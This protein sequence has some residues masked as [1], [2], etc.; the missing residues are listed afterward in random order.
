MSVIHLDKHIQ[1]DTTVCASGCPYWKPMHNHFS[2]TKNVPR[3]CHRLI[4]TGEPRPETCNVEALTKEFQ[5]FA[6]KAA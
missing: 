5:R 1:P 6:A 2:N 4:M 3:C